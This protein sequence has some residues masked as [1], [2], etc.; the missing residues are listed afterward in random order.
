MSCNYSHMSLHY[1]RNKRKIKLRKIDK[2][3]KKIKRKYK[4]PSTL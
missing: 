3:K 2:N 4:S 1:P